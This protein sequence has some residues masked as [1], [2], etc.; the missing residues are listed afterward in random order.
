M[1]WMMILLGGNVT[2]RP[3][4]FCCRLLLSQ[5]FSLHQSEGHIHVRGRKIKLYFPQ[6]GF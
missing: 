1:M 5:M 2:L 3:T 4:I 6:A